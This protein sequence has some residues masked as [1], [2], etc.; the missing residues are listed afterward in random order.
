MWGVCTEQRSVSVPRK[1]LESDSDD[2]HQHEG[3]LCSPASPRASPGCARTAYT[4][5]TCPWVMQPEWMWKDLRT[6]PTAPINCRESRSRYFLC[7]RKFHPRSRSPT[8]WNLRS[9]VA[10]VK[11][12]VWRQLKK[13]DFYY[14]FPNS[15]SKWKNETSFDKRNWKSLIRK[16]IKNIAQI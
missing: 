16:E 2:Q 6:D 11:L 15:Q 13:S 9:K 8:F 7:F 4:I 10:L 14:P 3:E 5:L 1:N 12:T